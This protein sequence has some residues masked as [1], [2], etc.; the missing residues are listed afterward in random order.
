VVTISSWACCSSELVKIEHLGWEVFADVILATGAQRAVYTHAAA[1]SSVLAGV[2]G[3]LC[4]GLR[5]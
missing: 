2:G 1:A 4:R 5:C 3:S